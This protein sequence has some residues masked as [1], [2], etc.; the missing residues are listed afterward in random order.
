MGFRARRGDAK[1]LSC[2]SDDLEKKPETTK[3]QVPTGETGDENV[4]VIIIYCY[5]RVTIATAAAACLSVRIAYLRLAGSAMA[6]PAISSDP[7]TCIAVV[8]TSTGRYRTSRRPSVFIY[9]C[10]YHTISDF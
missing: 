4:V 2:A 3:G 6:S 1:R 9:C 7:E 5:V 10:Y 8:Y